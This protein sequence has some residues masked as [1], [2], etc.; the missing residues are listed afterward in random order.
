MSKNEQINHKVMKGYGEST[1]EWKLP[2]VRAG[3]Q[4][5]GFIVKQ[6]V[7]QLFAYV[8]RVG[9]WKKEL[10]VDMNERIDRWIQTEMERL[11]VE[12]DGFTIEF[13]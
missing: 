4:R 12:L 6:L 11:K 3:R 8:G 7:W 1:S 2:L 10:T 13:E 5:L 9:G